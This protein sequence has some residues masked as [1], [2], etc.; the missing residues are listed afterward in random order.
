VI[1]DRVTAEAPPIVEY[2]PI[3]VDGHQGVDVVVPHRLPGAVASLSRPVG[4][5]EPAGG[6]AHSLFGVGECCFLVVEFEFAHRCE[7]SLAYSDNH[8]VRPCVL[9]AILSDRLA[10]EAHDNPVG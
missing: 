10:V 8:E 4:H 6:R 1:F 9:L 2:K 5:S 3:R 7:T